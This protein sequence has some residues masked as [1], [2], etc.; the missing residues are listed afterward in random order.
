SDAN[1]GSRPCTRSRPR[2]ADEMI[3]ARPDSRRAR[4]FVAVVALAIATTCGGCASLS[5]WIPDISLPSWFS[6]GKKLGPLPEFPTTANTQVVWQVALGKSAPGLAPAVTPN[7]IYAANA[8][9]AIVRVDP[10]TGAVVWRIEAARKLAAG[11][12]AD[13]TLVVVGTDKGDVL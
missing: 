8:S 2:G 9:G 6:S 11:V 7:A 4:A 3:A 13:A 12:G 10:A 1:T 5:S